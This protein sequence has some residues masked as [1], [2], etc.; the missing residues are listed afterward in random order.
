[1]S[2]LASHRLCC[3]FGEVIPPIGNVPKWAAISMNDI[4][5]ANS[6][7]PRSNVDRAELPRSIQRC[8]R[9][10][11]QIP[12]GIAIPHAASIAV[13]P[14]RNVFANLVHRSL[15]IGMLYVRE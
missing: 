3:E 11:T 6:G 7:V 1:M 8:G 13:V 10:A 12:R 15:L 2:A 9:S 4:P 14:R 5:S